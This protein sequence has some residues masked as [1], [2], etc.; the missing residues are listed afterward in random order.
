MRDQLKDARAQVVRIR[1]LADCKPGEVK[2][3]ATCKTCGKI[4][5]VFIKWAAVVMQPHRCVD[6]LTSRFIDCRYVCRE[7]NLGRKKPNFKIVWVLM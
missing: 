5:R 6:S 1:E 3:L 2:T 4:V 7:M